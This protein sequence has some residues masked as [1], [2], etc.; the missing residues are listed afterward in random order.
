[1]AFFWKSTT[2]TPYFPITTAP[3]IVNEENE[4]MS[5]FPSTTE[6]QYSIE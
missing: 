5:E 4:E 1:M 2:N 3:E 6:S